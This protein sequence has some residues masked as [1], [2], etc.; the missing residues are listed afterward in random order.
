[1]IIDIKNFVRNT[2][3]NTIKIWEQ[4]QECD[5]E[6]SNMARGEKFYSCTFHLSP[7]YHQWFALNI[8]TL[9]IPMWIPYDE[10]Q[11]GSSKVAEGFLFWGV[12]Q[13]QMHLVLQNM[14]T[15]L[16]KE[17]TNLTPF[18]CRL[19]MSW[20]KKTFPTLFMLGKVRHYHKTHQNFRARHPWATPLGEGPGEHAFPCNYEAKFPP[21]FSL[22]AMV[23]GSWWR[24]DGWRG[25]GELIEDDFICVLE[26]ATQ[27]NTGHIVNA[28]PLVRDVCK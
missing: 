8:C 20:A 16:M 25:K 1:M 15:C 21:M 19:P 7:I 28:G 4:H 26:F 27:L 13:F 22:P 2:L 11:Q 10:Q 23:V 5:R 24:N 14:Y 9:T 12:F 18:T 17:T 3:G 6:P